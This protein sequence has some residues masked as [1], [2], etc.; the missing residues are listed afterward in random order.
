MTLIKRYYNK[1]I[2]FNWLVD[3]KKLV[4]IFKP[5]AY[6]FEDKISSKVFKWYL[7]G[8]NEE[9]IIVKLNKYKKNDDDRKIII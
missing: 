3:G 1:N 7:K 9:E 5:D 6:I 2:I 4:D 8:L